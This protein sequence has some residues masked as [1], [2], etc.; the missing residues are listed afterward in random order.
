MD[1]LKKLHDATTPGPWVHQDD[2]YAFDVGYSWCANGHEI[3]TLDAGKYG[4]SV[5]GNYD[6]EAGGIIHQKDRDF[7]IA[8][9]NATPAILALV[10]AAR[11]YERCP[12]EREK[13]ISSA[14][15]A[16]DAAVGNDEGK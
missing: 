7:I 9:R 13:S 1:N 15:T 10:E 6:H 5:A 16:Y 3:T 12:I 4:A 11:D 8:M 2:P 14:I